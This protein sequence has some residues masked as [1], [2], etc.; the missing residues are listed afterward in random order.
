MTDRKLVILAIAAVIM[1][2]WA[3]LQSRLAD[4]AGRRPT[5]LRAPLVQGLDPD[6]IAQITI[7]SQDPE[8]TVT[9]SRA[10]SGFRVDQ[11]DRYPADIRAVNRLL[12]H[13]LDIR[14]TEYITDNPANHADLSVTEQTARYTVRFYDSDGQEITG[15]IISPTQSDPEGAYARLT[16]DDATYFIQSPPFL[17]TRPISYVDTTLL[18]VD[19]N[20]ISSVMVRGPD[21][22]Y[23]LLAS[24][25]EPGIYLDPMPDGM[26]FEGTAYRTVFGALSTLRFENVM[27]A[28]NAP[29]GLE[30]NH[31]YV[32]RLEDT[33]VYT[34]MLA[35][36]DGTFYA[37]VTADFMDTAAVQVGA[38]DSPETL[39]QKEAKLLAMDAA[40]MFARRHDGWVYTISSAKFE[41]LTQPM[42]ALLEEKPEP[43][44]QEPE[45]TEPIAE[46]TE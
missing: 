39:Q 14:L 6:A 27:A 32:C 25:N 33:T 9:L 37:T 8:Q 28:R 22:D 12:S 16:T 3:V 24:D 45:Q 20:A 29:D 44:P 35:Q 10:N 34:I 15:V 2:G 5:V 17:Q 21:G 38:D 23:V 31:S 36:D 30:F 42:E 11:K 26:Q 18:Q 4:R 41:D 43:E 46:D 13:C 7:T 40:E 19:R 1:T